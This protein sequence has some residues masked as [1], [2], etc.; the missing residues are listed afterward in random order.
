[1]SDINNKRDSSMDKRTL[2]AVVL[3]VVVIT[4]GLS[5]QAWLFPTPVAPPS[6]APAAVVPSLPAPTDSAASGG[7]VSATPEALAAP[8]AA[9]ALPAVE[10]PTAERRYTI[11]TDLLIASFSNSGGD[12]VSL[13]L[14]KH[15]EKGGFVDLV[16]PGP[17]KTRGFSLA[18]GG[19]AAAPVT[20]LMNTRMLDE[21]TIEFS[22]V[23][24]TR[25]PGA[26]EPT[27][28]T[29]RKTYSFR[30]GDYLFGLAI[31]LEGSDG[32]LA[33]L[34]EIPY[35]LSY[36]PRIGPSWVG[37]A[38]NADF[39]KIITL[40]GGKKKEERSK[41]A[42]WNPKNQPAWSAIA[43]KYFALI[44]IPS[45]PAYQT[46]Y[47]L[48][49]LG[50]VDQTAS[51]AFSRPAISAS[52]QTDTYYIYFGPKTQKELAKY[53][54]AEDNSFKLQGLQLESVMDSS[55]ILGWLEWLLKQA[56]YLFNALVGNYGVA[57]ILV[58][59]LVKA[60]L[61]PLSLKGSVATA[62][63]SDMQPKMKEVQDKYKANPQ[64]MNQ[65]L[66]ELYKREGYNPMSGC[67]PLLIQFPIFI[68]MYNLFNNH[69][70]LRG[71]SFI[72]GWIPD[73]SQPEALL[74]FP[75]VNLILWQVSALRALPIVYLASQLLYGKFTQMPQGGQS[76]GQMKFMM[77]GMPIMFFFILY[78][79][80]SGL[81]IYWIA[82]NVLQIGQQ[83][84]INKQVHKHKLALAAAAPSNE[85]VKK[86]GK[87]RI[88]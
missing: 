47:S 74:T 67:L 26:T 87:K 64:K 18:F 85:P 68:A 56:L 54:Y 48:G 37:S 44:A 71:A 30:E 72:P 35:T 55:N 14:K 83:V 5:I 49:A 41:T 77:Y 39:R 8:V 70:D 10:A 62:R 57:I 46:T 59:I 73:L 13:K 53:Q 79:V 32:A 16:V 42:T 23:L 80:P 63:M 21:R 31:T 66:A 12:L 58:T 81:L 1:M 6:A 19:T 7:L 65:E 25:L 61:F 75:T 50:T 38:K 84:V 27:P 86:V 4:V 15:K 88:P 40:Q 33:A 20:E 43:G 24:F 34:G 45:L 76:A 9:P 52:R 28:F 78:D 69:F 60:V 36:G 2:L 29:Y 17:D 3:S 51:L 82:S 22:R 11:E